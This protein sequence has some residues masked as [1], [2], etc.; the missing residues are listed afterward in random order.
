MACDFLRFG[1]G[2]KIFTRQSEKIL[3]PFSLDLQT[4]IRAFSVRNLS[5]WQILPH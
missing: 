1:S 2:G 3:A 4:T 5:K